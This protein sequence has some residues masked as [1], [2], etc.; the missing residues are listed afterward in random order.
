M[1]ERKS[2]SIRFW[3]TRGTCVP[4]APCPE[5]GIHTTAV[6]ITAGDAAPI[7]VDMGTGAIC[8]AE[9][10]L[11]AGI[12][13]YDVFLT[14]LHV[15]HLC[16]CFA[17]APFHISDCRVRIHAVDTGAEA[18]L[19]GLLKSPYYP[20]SFDELTAE[21]EFDYLAARA[22]RS[23]EEHG[24]TV[25]WGPLAHPQ[26]SVA[27]RFDDG[28]NAIVFATDVELGNDDPNEDLH[29]LL[30]QP[31]PAGLAV[32]DGYFAGKEVDAYRNWGHS[33]WQQ[34]RD[35]GRQAGASRVVVTHHHP[36]RG[37]AELRG[38]EQAADDV[39]WAREAQLWTL[40]RNHAELD[41]R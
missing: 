12:R 1:S 7:F 11:Q 34:A 32:I 4:L 37:D 28:E 39:S 30:S 24:C 13:C 23:M 26:G 29:R 19:R 18:A 38:F 27:L 2:L 17:F 36:N 31:Y 21:V 6:E 15:D 41:Q 10:A 9:N 20:V 3:G 40:T 8:A 5:F 33:S 35:V 25:S 16:G 22:Q 14:H